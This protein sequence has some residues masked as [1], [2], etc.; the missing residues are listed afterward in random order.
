MFSSS[1][2]ARIVALVLSVFVIFGL[3]SS[4][5]LNAAATSPRVVVL[6]GPGAVAD[7]VIAQLATCEVSGVDRL[8]GADRYATAAE[9]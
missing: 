2:S 3:S 8:F 5:A 4:V 1:S 7:G 9:I 6:G